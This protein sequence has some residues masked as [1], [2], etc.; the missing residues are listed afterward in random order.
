[1]EAKALKRFPEVRYGNSEG[2]VAYRQR[3]YIHLVHPPSSQW[4]SHQLQIHR[5]AALKLA[6]QR[7]RRNKW[8]L[9]DFT[10]QEPFLGGRLRDVQ[11][12]LVLLS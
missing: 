4:A 8:I 1:M 10:K 2:D 5:Y 7:K 12:N 3:G 11:Y 9:P 6:S